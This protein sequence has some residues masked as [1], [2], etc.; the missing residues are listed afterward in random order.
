M[1]LYG[2]VETY[3][4]IAVSE[5]EVQ[6]AREVTW[7]NTLNLKFNFLDSYINPILTVRRIEFARIQA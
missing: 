2:F 1:K 7:P 4:A 5:D 6:G 3:E